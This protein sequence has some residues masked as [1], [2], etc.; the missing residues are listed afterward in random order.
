[1]SSNKSAPPFI[2]RLRVKSVLD[3]IKMNLKSLLSDVAYLNYYKGNLFVLGGTGSVLIVFH[4]KITKEGDYIEYN[5]STNE[6][7]WTDK[8]EMQSPL[9]KYIPVVCI[10]ESNIDLL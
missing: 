4:T 1:V 5:M 2:I 6:W 10:E 8:M 7:R 9:I 3:L